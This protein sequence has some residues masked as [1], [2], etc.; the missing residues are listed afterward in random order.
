MLVFHGGTPTW[1]LHTGLCKFVQN[2]LTNI[3]SLGTLKDLKFGQV[4]SLPVS[5]NITISWLYPLNGFRFN[6]ILRDSASQEF[7]KKKKK[8]KK[9]KGIARLSF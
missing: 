4:S 3:W 7:K 9:E 8:K 2:I 6:V 1:L 5:Y